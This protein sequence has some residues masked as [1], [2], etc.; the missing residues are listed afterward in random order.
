M[1]IHRIST[2]STK[3]PHHHFDL[4]GHPQIFHAIHIFSTLSFW[5]TW[6]S[7]DFPHHPHIFHT[8]ILI[9]NGPHRCFDPIVGNAVVFSYMAFHQ[10]FDLNSCGFDLFGTFWIWALLQKTYVDLMVDEWRQW[11]AW[12][13]AQGA[14]RMGRLFTPFSPFRKV[15][16]LLWNSSLAIWVGEL[17]VWKFQTP[18]VK[19]KHFSDLLCVISSDPTLQE[20]IYQYISVY[21]QIYIYIYIYTHT[22]TE[23]VSASHFVT[24]N[25]TC[26][27]SQPVVVSG[28][29]SFY[30]NLFE[31][32][33]FC[34]W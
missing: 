9:W 15:Q 2:P 22:H 31:P 24:G 13:L 16:V 5:F 30:Y 29:L 32:V 7:T 4:D 27:L 33:N 34:Y 20:C 18:R 6:P 26:V 10:V 17:Q 21:T 12:G 28:N 1:A 19:S 11:R 3:L 14:L 25:S 23:I 8:A